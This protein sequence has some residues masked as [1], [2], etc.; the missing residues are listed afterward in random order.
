MRRNYD[1]YDRIRELG[2]ELG[3]FDGNVS[4][5]EGKNIADVV[6]DETGLVYL[7]GVGLG[8]LP[9]TDDPERVAYGHQAGRDAADVHIR[10][11]HWGALMCGGEGGDLNDVLCT[12]KAIGMVV[13]TNLDFKSAPAV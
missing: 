3:S 2:I 1:V 11:L 10:W 7:S 12:V 13:S 5:V 8:E 9:M 6:I 4:S